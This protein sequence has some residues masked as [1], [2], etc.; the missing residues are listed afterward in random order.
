MLISFDIGIKN[1]SY[2]IFD[3]TKSDYKIIK[4]DIINLCGVTYKCC[5]ESKKGNKCTK[6]AMYLENE[7]YYCGTHV[8]LVK[9]NNTKEIKQKKSSDIS[10]ID[11]GC[12]LS[13]LLPKHL[14]LDKIDT[15][16]IENQI[17]PLANRM[18]TIQGMLAQFFIEKNI[19]NIIFVSSSNKLKDFNVPKKTYADRKKSSIIVL[20]QL[21]L[22]NKS[23]IKW[24]EIFNSHQKKDDL[25][26]SF[27]QGLW[28]INKYY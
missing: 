10:L 22:E 17:S 7:K 11:I 23:L 14:P 3:G 13:D 16:I 4:W 9:T 24:Q 1:L 25:A 8:K 20:K 26:D 2:C 6:N 28:Y 15:V 21:L 27:L 19:R 18:K 5:G 12:S